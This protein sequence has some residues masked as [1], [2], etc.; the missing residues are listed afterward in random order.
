MNSGQVGSMR[1]A[2]YISNRYNS[3]P[4]DVKHFMVLAEAQIKKKLDVAQK[5]VDRRAKGKSFIQTTREEI[6]DRMS[7]FG[8]HIRDPRQIKKAIIE[9]WNLLSRMKSEM[10]VPSAKELP[11]AFKNLDLCLT[12]ALYLEAIGEYLRKGGQS[13]GSYLVLNPKGEKPLKELGDEWKFRMNE[14]DSFVDKKILEIFLDEQGKIRK[15]WVDARPIP[16]EENWF[17]NVWLDYLKG[18]IIR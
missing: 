11:Q 18:D 9:A 12:H 10:R 2:M 5:L 7:N 6:Q 1:L 16:Q 15:Q 8:A 13:R 3:K 17:E 14:K 4:Q